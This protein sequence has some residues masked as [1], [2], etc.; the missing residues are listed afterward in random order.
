MT[1]LDSLTALRDAVR[2]GRETDDHFEAVWTA[3]DQGQWR[4]NCWAVNACRNRDMNA[5]LALHEAVLP[6]WAVE[7]LGNACIDGTGGWV[8]RIVAPDYLESFLHGEG[9]AP[10]PARAWLL[11]ILSALIAKEGEE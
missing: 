3:N 6:G 7:N 11:A 2:E 5:A 9:T 8:V 4:L 1:R 10:T